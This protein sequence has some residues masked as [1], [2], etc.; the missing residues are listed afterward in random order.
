MEKKHVLDPFVEELSAEQLKKV[1]ELTQKYSGIIWS[2]AYKL[3]QEKRENIPSPYVLSSVA[4]ALFNGLRGTI[5]Q[6][7]VINPS[8]ASMLR[9][10]IKKEVAKW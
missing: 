8:A 6:L 3:M 4:R 9:D 10:S 7:A 5:K 1:I 2:T